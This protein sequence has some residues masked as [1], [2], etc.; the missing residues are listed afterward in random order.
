MDTIAKVRW[1]K[2]ANRRRPEQSVA[3]AVFLM[4]SA[5]DANRCIVEGLKICGAKV[6]PTK[7]KQEP[8]QCMKCRRWGHFASDCTQ[9]RD[10]C[11]TCGGD[12]RTNICN[13]RNKRYCASCND[14]SHASW[15]RNCPEFAKRCSWYDKKHPDN[16]LKYFPTGETWTQTARP[17]HIPIP[18]RFPARFAVGSLPPPLTGTEGI[19]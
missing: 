14:H 5:K 12:H 15:D 1:I 10:T 17:E 18:E 7:L 11:G 16:T 6:Y 19:S 8:T 4:S 2:P 9:S 13:N 3:H